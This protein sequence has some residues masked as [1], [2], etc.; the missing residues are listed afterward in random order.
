[1]EQADAK[2]AA[3][4]SRL[5]A[6]AEAVKRLGTNN[7]GMQAQLVAAQQHGE[8]QAQTAA[9]LLETNVR[10]HETV[11]TLLE[12][13]PANVGVTGPPGHVEQSGATMP[14]LQLEGQRQ[15]Q[16]RGM[17]ARGRLQQAQRTPRSSG[18]LLVPHEGVRSR[19]GSTGTAADAKRPLGRPQQQASAQRGTAPRSVDR[20]SQ[21]QNQ[22]NAAP[23][24]HREATARQ[25]AV[26]AALQLLSE[27]RSLLA[28]QRTAAAELQGVA[29]ALARAPSGSQLELLHRHARLQGKLREV[30]AQLE[31]RAVRL[32]AL[33][34]QDLL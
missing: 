17:S 16:Q 4:D 22:L 33:R 34:Q 27:H 14:G 6:V 13:C 29:G 30:A 19:L 15:Q 23:L 11:L 3:L 10:L 2:A 21:Q 24:L 9:A 20:P 26:A 31:D 8:R 1:V 18:L 25:A 12:H 7:A 5:L 28:V 32:A